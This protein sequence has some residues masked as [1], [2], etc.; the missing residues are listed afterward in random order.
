MRMLEGIRFFPSSLYNG[1]VAELESTLKQ[2]IASILATTKFIGAKAVVLTA[3]A[4]RGECTMYA[5]DG[6]VLSDVEVT[7][8]MNN[9]PL[10]PV[11]HVLNLNMLKATLA[12]RDSCS[13]EF[14][15]RSCRSLLFATPY[16]Y[17][18]KV[19]GKVLLG[20]ASVKAI[21]TVEAKTIPRWEGVKL[22]CNRIV[23]FIH[24]IGPEHFRGSRP[25]DKYVRYSCTK[26]ILACLEAVLIAHRQYAPSCVD[27]M[28]AFCEIYPRV[29]KEHTFMRDLLQLGTWATDFKLCRGRAQIEE[30]DPRLILR[31]RDI[32]L[33]TLHYVA[34]VEPT[35][36]FGLCK[37]VGNVSESMFTDLYYTLSA[38]CFG[39]PRRRP[40]ANIYQAAIHVLSGLRE[41]C[42]DRPDLERAVQC[43]RPVAPSSMVMDE[44]DVEGVSAWCYALYK[45]AFQL[46]SLPTMEEHFPVC[47][48]D[49][50]A[51]R[52]AS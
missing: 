24:V 43:L 17:D 14:G 47:L 33:T 16:V 2:E 7:V 45:K 19:H 5:P 29:S 35:D 18:F 26:A 4:A 44:L 52:I 27:R 37:A 46:H 8:V 10:I 34:E 48:I 13:L 40:I 22:V 42:V 39:L 6:T 11:V 20:D 38:R 12:K 23:E 15:L 31:T 32:L 1:R 49:E 25:L 9:L 21:P 36:I 51:R 41:H 28:R 30:Q 50:R 3:S